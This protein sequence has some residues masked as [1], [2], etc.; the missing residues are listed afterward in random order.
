MTYEIPVLTQ[1]AQVLR[2]VEKNPGCDSAAISEELDIDQNTAN[3]NCQR[4]REKGKLRRVKIPGQ[5]SA[6]WWPGKEEGFGM[7]PNAH[8]KP[9][10]QTVSEW[11]PCTLRDPLIDALFGRQNG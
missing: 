7:L 9:K 1:I 8:D 3:T 11:E 5:R 2:F 10:R 4:L 6:T